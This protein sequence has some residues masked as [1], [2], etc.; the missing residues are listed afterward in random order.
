MGLLEWT[1]TRR[2]LD[3][4]DAY[5]LAA[6]GIVYSDLVYSGN[7]VRPVFSLLSSIAYKSGSGTQSDPIIIN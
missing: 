3:S 7:S 5:I 4:T 1:I 2:S 6:D